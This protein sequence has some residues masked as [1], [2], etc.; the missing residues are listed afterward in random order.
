MHKYQYGRISHGGYNTN[1]AAFFFS[2]MKS[3][4]S[5]GCMYI[6][7]IIQAHRLSPWK[8]V[9]LSGIYC[10]AEHISRWIPAVALLLKFFVIG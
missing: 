1:M 4:E 2:C 6:F 10:P 8:L 9:Q 5:E 3:F 7:N